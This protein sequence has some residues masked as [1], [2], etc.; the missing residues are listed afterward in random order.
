MEIYFSARKKLLLLIMFF[1]QM[2]NAAVV[3]TLKSGDVTLNVENNVDGTYAVNFSAYGVKL[4]ASDAYNPTLV[5]V[6]NPK[7]FYCNYTGVS[8]DADSLTL[9]ADILATPS[10]VRFHVIDI[11]KADGDGG[12]TLKRDVKVVSAGSNPYK[13]GF[14]SSFGLQLPKADNI[15]AYDRFIPAV[16]YNAN[17]ESAGNIP[18]GQPSKDDNNFLYRDDRV[19]LP[20]VMMRDTTSGVTT[21]VVET[22]SPCRTILKDSQAATADEIGMDADYQFGGVGLTKRRRTDGF[23]SVVTFPGS[24]NHT[25]GLGDRRHPITDGFDRHHYEVYFKI[26]KSAD[27]ASAVRQSWNKAF[28][29]YNPKIYTVDLTHACDALINTVDYYYMSPTRSESKQNVNVYAA[30]FP[31]GVNLRDFSLNATTYE[32]GFVGAQTEAGYALLRGG[33]DRKDENLR[34]HGQKV[35]SFWALR[36]LSDLGFP[37][38]RYY[39]IQ[40]VW[41]NATCSMRQACTGMTAI[42]EA[43]CYYQKYDGSNK[44]TWMNACKKFGE[45]LLANQNDDG[46]YYMEYNPMQVVN[47]KHPVAKDNKYLTICAVRYL[48]EMYIATGD[49]RYKTAALRAAEWSYEHIHKHYTYVACVVDNPQT[50]DSESGQQA[51]QGFLSIYDLTKNPKW[52]EAAE[53]AATYTETYTYMHEVP[54]ETD[55]TADTDWPRDRSIVGQH[56]IAAWQSASDLGFVWSSF[57]YYRLYLYTGNEHYLHVARISAHDTKQSMNLY[58]KLYPGQ[59]EGLQQEA[60]GV[61]TRYNSPRRTHSVM[62]ALTWN[63]AAHLDPMI[64]FKDAFGTPDMEKVAEMPLDEQRQLNEQYSINQSADHS[65]S[66]GISAVKVDADDLQIYYAD[67]L[68]VSANKP[69]DCVSVYDVPG[70]CIAMTENAK[71]SDESVTVPVSLN[72]GCYIVKV[73]FTDKQ[74]STVKC[75]VK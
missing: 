48:V 35:L 47:G 41:D 36:G 2:A 17:F 53:Q 59:Q 73:K 65:W 70:R 20:L 11:Y 61:P 37:K 62:E 31:W 58:Q 38:S 14:Y 74:A 34:L 21:M 4:N 23:A 46:S 22:N 9:T 39:C 55:Q 72:K 44:I 64:R 75:L 63:F 45:W 67:G 1:T 26:Y 27:Y 5:L 8:A 50:V 68:H 6:C 28:D 7:T 60:F 40:G 19:T 52:L 71:I 54:V 10:T 3:N 30:G 18:S 33:L 13:N 43:W 56:L 29:L 42:L 57:C 66:T 32:I 24:D 69:V 15:L 12:F 51:M 16:I 25:T 49:E